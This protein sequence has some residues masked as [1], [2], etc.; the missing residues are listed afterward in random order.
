MA[1]NIKKIGFCFN[2]L[3]R[4]LYDRALGGQAVRSFV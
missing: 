4:E 1:E 3:F 2:H